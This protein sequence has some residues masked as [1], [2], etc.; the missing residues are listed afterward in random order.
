MKGLSVL[1]SLLCCFSHLVS[2]VVV[3]CPKGSNLGCKCSE[4]LGNFKV[5]CE[6]IDAIQEIPSWIPNNTKIL[7]FTKSDIRFLN[8]HSFKNLV[9][10]TDIKIEESK[11]GLTFV[12]RFVF[13]GLPHLSAVHFVD[14]RI[15]AL[16]A[17]LFAN[18]PSL[19]L[20]NLNDNPVQILPDDLF[21]NTTEVR[22]FELQNT[23]L[24]QSV[25][26]NIG[27]GHF[28]KNIDDLQ[29]SGTHIE[30]V[31]DGF[32]SGLPKLKNL[33]M[34][35]SGVKSI[36]A[37]IL[38]DTNVRTLVLDGNLLEV[39]DENA[40]G[41]SKLGSFQCNG[42]Q[43]TSNVAFSG[44]LKKITSLNTIIMEN[45]NLTHI[46][47]D[48]FT[49]LRLLS[50]IRLSNNNISTIEENPYAGLPACDSTTCV[51]LLGNP[52]NC[53][54]NLIPFR[55]FVDTINDVSNNKVSWKCAEPQSVAGKSLISLK[56]SQFCCE[57]V[58]A[59]KKCGLSNSGWIISAHVL[60]AVMSQMLV[61]F[62][63]PLLFA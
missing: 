45:N 42:C 33:A 60:F 62:G 15:T 54:C 50:V 5:Q 7:E 3:T 37:N 51:Q 57:T 28:G 6:N 9:N 23:Q 61:M 29:L 47:K 30:R 2:S 38:K 31:L 1:I 49:G 46:P 24:Q 14:N 18:L 25:I 10:L 21:E 20:V 22:Y 52:F 58:T 11:N 16:P 35:N 34:F 17:G 59:T 13:Q 41:D 39:I 19:V 53:D 36:G 12:D 26:Q 56:I 8:R 40:F 48:A 43:L 4:T 32:F 27:Q 44:F 63:I 55:Q